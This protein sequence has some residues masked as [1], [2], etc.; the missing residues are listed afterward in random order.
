MIPSKW[1][2]ELAA[3]LRKDALWWERMHPEAEL[4][5][6]GNCENIVAMLQN[7]AGVRQ[8]RP[9]YAFLY[10]LAELIDRPTW[11]CKDIGGEEGTNGEHY[12][13]ACSRCGFCSDITEPNYCPNC[14]AEVVE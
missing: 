6:S 4:Y 13:F 7:G 11:T 3:K 10:Y 14:G 12:D 2:R 8:A 1:R 9:M 5:D